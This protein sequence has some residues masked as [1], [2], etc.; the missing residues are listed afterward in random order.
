MTACAYWAPPFGCAWVRDSP[1][2]KNKKRVCM[3]SGFITYP[4]LLSPG[5]LFCE[6]TR[7]RKLLFYVFILWRV[8]LIF[9]CGGGCTVS[10]CRV[11]NDVPHS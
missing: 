9:C 3:K 8:F 6:E 4:V 11:R 5:S 1:P 2:R 10:P 7:K